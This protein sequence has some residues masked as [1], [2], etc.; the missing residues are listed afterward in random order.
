MSNQEILNK[1][2]AITRFSEVR[3]P[4]RPPA[5]RWHRREQIL[6]TCQDK[7]QRQLGVMP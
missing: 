2:T 6:I 7:V 1:K 4:I 5:L 3:I